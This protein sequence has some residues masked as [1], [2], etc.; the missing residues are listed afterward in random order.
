MPYLIL[1]LS[2]LLSL[3]ARAET[4]RGGLCFPETSQE[5][6]DFYR[7]GVCG[8]YMV[9]LQPKGLSNKGISIEADRA[10]VL[11]DFDSARIKPEFL[12]Q[13]RQWGEALAQLSD[14]RFR[15]EGHADMKGDDEYNDKLSLRR[16]QK[17]KYYLVQNFAVDATR[18]TVKGL[19]ES[20]PL[21][22]F[23]PSPDEE[24]RRW[25]RRVELIKLPG[26]GFPGSG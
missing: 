8:D 4:I 18:L 14:L 19:G 2:L 11:F 21:E 22:G 7:H 20:R 13:L 5:I 16:A 26:S 9:G 25:N 23:P 3:S 12:Q 17:L 10:A 15:L 24:Q 6:I 1:L